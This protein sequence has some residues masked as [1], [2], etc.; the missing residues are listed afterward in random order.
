MCFY[1]H[2]GTFSKVDFCMEKGPLRMQ[3]EISKALHFT[4]LGVQL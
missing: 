4:L 1:L 3:E 2:H